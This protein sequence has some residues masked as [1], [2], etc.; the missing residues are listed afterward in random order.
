MQRLWFGYGM[1][2]A[3]HSARAEFEQIVVPSIFDKAFVMYD[4]RDEMI[5]AALCARLDLDCMP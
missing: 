4:T 5:A 3:S 1:E 2:V